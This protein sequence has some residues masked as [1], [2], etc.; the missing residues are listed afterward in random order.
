MTTVLTLTAKN[1]LTL[2]EEMLNFLG[3]DRGNKLWTRIEEQ[4]I[5][6]EKV[7]DSWNDLQGTLKD[8]VLT[9]GKSV[10]EIIELAKKKEAKRLAKKYDR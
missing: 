10:L 7:G 3:I 1:Q 8:T 2:P 6:I 9:K 4:A 5:V